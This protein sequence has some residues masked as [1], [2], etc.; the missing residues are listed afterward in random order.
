MNKIA[1]KV[2]LYICSILFLLIVSFLCYAA[3]TKTCYIT[4]QLASEHTFFLKD[5]L[6]LNIIISVVF[7]LL[8]YAIS[9]FNFI[10]KTV[11]K[12]N[13]DDKLF[14]C[15]KNILLL[16]LFAFGF[17]WVYGTQVYPEGD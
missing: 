5:N 2:Y 9:R 15:I 12:I 16:L 1:D 3:Y 17:V 7:I 4:I 8:I 6:L 11:D 10:K 13:T 14:G